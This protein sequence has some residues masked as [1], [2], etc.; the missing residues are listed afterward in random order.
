M[1]GSGRLRSETRQAGA[2]SGRDA[3]ELRVP[4]I[5]SVL[6]SVLRHERPGPRL[7]SLAC[8]R[9]GER[10]GE[11]KPAA[12]LLIVLHLATAGARLAG[13]DVSGEI[14]LHDEAVEAVADKGAGGELPGLL[15]GAVERIAAVH[16]EV[17]GAVGD[18][19][20]LEP[21]E[22]FDQRQVEAEPVRLA[23]RPERPADGAAEAGA[24]VQGQAVGERRREIVVAVADIGRR[25]ALAEGRRGGLRQERRA[26]EAEA[27]EPRSL[28]GR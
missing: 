10:H 7:R 13:D 1:G 14:D 28:T 26:V 5:P 18:R 12:G 16:R 17:E 27:S 24:R 4:S 15:I 9:C 19:A 25:E 2:R 21:P 20:D 22:P 6:R 3:F 23:D 11:A 8:A